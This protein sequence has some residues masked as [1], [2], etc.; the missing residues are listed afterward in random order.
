MP[1]GLLKPK[2]IPFCVFSKGPS[3]DAHRA[4]TALQMALFSTQ[5]IYKGLGNEAILEV[6]RRGGEG[7]WLLLPFDPIMSFTSRGRRRCNEE[8]PFPSPGFESRSS[9]IRSRPSAS[10]LSQ[11][12][13][14]SPPR[15]QADRRA[16]S[17]AG[18]ASLECQLFHLRQSGYL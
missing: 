12:P 8:A 5:F 17:S 6:C 18:D 2:V 3:N 11:G 4:I 13:G 7:G 1:K 16:P 10:V 15:R 14:D 9:R